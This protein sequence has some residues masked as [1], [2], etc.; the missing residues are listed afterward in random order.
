AIR[1]DC[2]FEVFGRTAVKIVVAFMMLTGTL[3]WAGGDDT[4]T[5][6]NKLNFDTG[7]FQQL[8]SLLDNNSITSVEDFLGRWKNERPE[9]YTNY[10]MAYRSRSLQG[11]SPE[12]P[13]VLMFSRN[14]D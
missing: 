7:S 13:R 11:A 8:Q 9:F 12:D 4:Y 6:S 2:L 1:V 10:V 14:A 3:A 5:L